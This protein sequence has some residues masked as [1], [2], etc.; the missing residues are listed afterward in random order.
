[1]DEPNHF[2]HRSSSVR[3]NARAQLAEIRRKRLAR[4]TKA[5]STGGSGEAAGSSAPRNGPLP[6]AGAGHAPLP[7]GPDVQGDTVTSS[8]KSAA[9]GSPSPLKAACTAGAG[10]TAAD[11]DLFAL[12]GAGVGLV[13]M[14]N[15]AGVRSLRDLADADGPQLTRDLGLIGQ[16]MDVGDWIVFARKAC[17]RPTRQPDVVP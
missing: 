1:M 10:P 6:R 3:A 7:A 2:R 11:S 15:T 14:L 12:P 4:R 9:T 13:W 5:A 16:I 8:P 17:E